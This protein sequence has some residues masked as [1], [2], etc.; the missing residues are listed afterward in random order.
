MSQVLLVDAS[1]RPLRVIALRRALCLLLAGKAELI[2][3]DPTREVRTAGGDSLRVPAV[4]R[5]NYMVNIPF[6]ASVPL[7]RRALRARDEDQCQVRGCNRK[8][9][10]VDHLVPRSKDG[11]TSWMNCV[12]MC[13]PHNTKKAN[14]TLTEMGWALKKEPVAPRGTVALVPNLRSVDPAWEPY[15]AWLTG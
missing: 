14:R 15:L 4:V 5:L 3:E 1:F 11:V 7:T 9:D 6:R 13:G 8:G 2:E 10:T 12:L